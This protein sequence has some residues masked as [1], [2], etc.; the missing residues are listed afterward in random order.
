M[1]VSLFTLRA[2]LPS[3]TAY[4][5]V[6]EQLVIRGEISTEGTIRVDG[7]IEGRLHRADT[8]I[9]GTN[10]VVVGDIEAREVIVSGTV[11]GN[12]VADRRVELHASASVRGDVR[13]AAMLLHEGG[14]MNG[15][16]IVARHEMPV[17]GRRLELT[18]TT[19]ATTT[20]ER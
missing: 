8:L 11:E 5:V 6:D 17:E 3:A 19:G 20:A 1:P 2:N 12:I 18:A 14:S 16:V 7:R 13:S 10:G 15:H 4:S 9:I